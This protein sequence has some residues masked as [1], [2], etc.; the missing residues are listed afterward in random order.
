[1]VVPIAIGSQDCAKAEKRK[2]YMAAGHLMMDRSDKIFVAGYRG[3]VGS[4]L[5]RL[6]EQE[7]FHNL[8]K[9]DR[10]QLDWADERAVHNFFTEEKPA[11][12]IFAAAKV[13]GIK[14]NND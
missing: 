10:S 12:V 5:I 2:C 13:G 9:R 3:L 11:I 7:G 6:L 4:A 14:A 1:M 8:P